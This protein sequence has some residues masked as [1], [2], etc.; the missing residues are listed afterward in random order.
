MPDVEDGVGGVVGA[1]VDDGVFGVVPVVAIS[2][3]NRPVIV[4]LA[5]GRFAFLPVDCRFALS[6]ELE[7]AEWFGLRHVVAAALEVVS[8]TVLLLARS[9]EGE[10]FHAERESDLQVERFAWR[11]GV[12]L[13]DNVADPGGAIFSGPLRIFEGDA[14]CAGEQGMS[15]LFGAQTNLVEGDDGALDPAVVAVDRGDGDQRALGAGED[16][17]GVVRTVI[18]GGRTRALVARCG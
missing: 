12:A 14:I 3:E 4:A 11:F 9:G 7:H 17:R 6:V 13:G 18:G 5:G 10:R 8:N 15:V 2:N 1:L 16:E